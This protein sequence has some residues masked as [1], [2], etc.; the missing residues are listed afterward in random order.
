[1]TYKESLDWQKKEQAFLNTLDL[2]PYLDKDKSISD[3]MDIIEDRH[4]DEYIEEEYIFN[5]MDSWDFIK[6]LEKRYPNFQYYEYNEY[7]VARI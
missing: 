6:Y 5:C 4:N 1:M 7:R 3:I 2:I